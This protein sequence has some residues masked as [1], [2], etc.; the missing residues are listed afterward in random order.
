LGVLVDAERDLVKAF[1]AVVNRVHRG[2][3]G[4]EGLCGADI[5]GGAV[6]PNVLFA[7]LKGEAEGG[8]ALRIFGYADKTARKKPLVG[9]S[10]SKV[11]CMRAPE[12]DRNTEALGT[13]YGNVGP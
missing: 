11:S 1:G 5:A 8:A 3:G 10:S 6:S 12:T 7:C 9:E 4:Q 13:T 2:E